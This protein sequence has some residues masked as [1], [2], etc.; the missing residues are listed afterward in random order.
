MPVNDKGAHL[1]MEDLT[2]DSIAAPS[3]VRARIKASKTDQFRRGADIFVGI[4][5]NQLCPVEA[6]LAYIAQ[7]GT[8]PGFFRFEDGRLLTKDCFI[9][10]VRSALSASGVDA[11]AYAGHSFRIGVATSAARKG[12][13]PEKIQT[14]GRWVSSAYLLYMYIRLSR[15]ELAEVSRTISS[16]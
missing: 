6:V 11:K 7:Q 16:P 8:G 9:S 5:H 3:M 14:L 12:I 15:A 4:T 10:N 1:N 2:V 13:A